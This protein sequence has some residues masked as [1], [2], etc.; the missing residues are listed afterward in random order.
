[1]VDWLEALSLNAVHL[2]VLPVVLCLL[3]L[4]RGLI[5]ASRENTVTFKL[6]GLGVEIVFNSER[7]PK[8][9]NVDTDKKE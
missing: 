6:R 9:V 4:A 8:R 7:H 1:M 5:R 3:I 2:L